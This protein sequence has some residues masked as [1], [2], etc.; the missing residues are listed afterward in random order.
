MLTNISIQ[1]AHG[2][3]KLQAIIS[4]SKKLP[5]LLFQQIV[6]T[7]NLIFLKPYF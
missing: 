7:K 4:T 1:I 6:F 2:P 5:S 3:S